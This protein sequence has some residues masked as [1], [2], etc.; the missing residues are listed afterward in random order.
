MKM[1]GEFSS[2]EMGGIRRGKGTRFKGK[3]LV[4]SSLPRRTYDSGGNP[5]QV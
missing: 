1:G 2:S 3:R 4:Y 5:K